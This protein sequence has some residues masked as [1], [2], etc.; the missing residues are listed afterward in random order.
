MTEQAKFTY[1]PLGKALEKQ[2]KTNEDQGKKQ[3]KAIEDY[4][5]Q[6]VECNELI[7][8]DFNIDKDSIANEKQK[9]T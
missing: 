7:I 3:I 5:K 8:K 9:I 4:G 2:A 6:L 1:F